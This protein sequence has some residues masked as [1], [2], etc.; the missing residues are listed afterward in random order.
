MVCLEN[1]HHCARWWSQHFVHDKQGPKPSFLVVGS[2]AGIFN[3]KV[4]Q[5]EL[6]KKGLH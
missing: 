4:L 3:A 6:H 1:I 5:A 2:N